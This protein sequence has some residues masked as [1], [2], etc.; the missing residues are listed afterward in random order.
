MKPTLDKQLHEHARDTEWVWGYDFRYADSYHQC[1]SCG[2][3][4]WDDKRVHAEGCALEASLKATEA[5]L[6][7]EDGLHREQDELEDEGG[8]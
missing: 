6:R 8:G 1:E 5:F 2:A 3:K 7:V 4:H